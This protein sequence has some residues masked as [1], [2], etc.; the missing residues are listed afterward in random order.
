DAEPGAHYFDGRGEMFLDE[1]RDSTV[2]HHRKTGILDVPTHDPQR[3]REELLGRPADPREAVLSA[4]HNR[5]GRA[6]AEQSGSD[7]GRRVV[8]IETDRDRAGLDGDE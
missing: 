7:D 3:V 8:A 1:R 2:E 4:G 6:V 5:R